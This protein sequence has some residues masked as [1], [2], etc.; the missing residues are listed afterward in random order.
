MKN[1]VRCS[2]R[3]NDRRRSPAEPLGS[4][5]RGGEAS[6]SD[7]HVPKDLRVRR[8]LANRRSLGLAYAEDAKG[9][10]PVVHRDPGN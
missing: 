5:L 1:P 2:R 7:G 9:R 10:N 6:Q 8:G 3:S 4:R